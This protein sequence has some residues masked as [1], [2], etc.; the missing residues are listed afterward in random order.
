MVL[1]RFG[2]LDIPVNNAGVFIAKPLTDYAAVW[3]QPRRV[4]L[5][6]PA[7]HRQDGQPVRRPRGQCLGR[8]RR[9]RELRHALVLAALTK[10][11]LA[12]ATRSLAAGYASR[13]ILI[14]AWHPALS[15]PRCT[16]RTATEGPPAGFPRSAGPAR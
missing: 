8:H 10:G 15:I 14:N 2:R 12:A 1:D 9:G 6:C 5:A 7:R 13:G 11:S 16:Q 4:L 3:G